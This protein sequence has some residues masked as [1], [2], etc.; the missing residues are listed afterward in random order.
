[1][2]KAILFLLTLLCLSS[3]V[4][5]VGLMRS[6]E[7][8]E[9]NTS[10]YYDLSMSIKGDSSVK[11]G[12]FFVKSNSSNVEIEGDSIYEHSITLS[13]YEVE[14][15]EVRLESSI[16]GTYLVTWGFKISSSQE[17]SM[18]SILERSVLMKVECDGYCG[19]NGNESSSS[20]TSSSTKRK[21]VKPSGFLWL[22]SS[23]Y[24]EINSSNSSLVS[25]VSSS[26]VDP[27][28]SSLNSDESVVFSDVQEDSSVVNVPSN[29][30]VVESLN[31]VEESAG[32]TDSN[33]NVFYLF[34]SLGI[35][36]VLLSI[37]VIYYIRGV[38]S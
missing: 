28:R 2:K 19:L 25:P 23:S 10:E 27:S 18:D 11:S 17:G 8:I 32:I 7:T 13:Q 37:G 30:F 26:G 24:K 14:S 35:V 16:P 20:S 33:R 34:F 9:I 31:A 36:F 5:A 4:S 12:V 15:D 3:F 38:D 6:V 1:M 29:Q 21:S 22:N